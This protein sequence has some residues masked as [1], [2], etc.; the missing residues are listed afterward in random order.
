MK[1][2]ISLSFLLV[3]FLAI[4]QDKI[5]YI[6]YDE[7]VAEVSKLAIDK[8]YDKVLESLNKISKNDSTYCSVLT[9]K[10][11]Y[12]IQQEKYNEA[13]AITN[14]GL[15]LDCDSGSKLFFTM[16]KGVSLESL[17]RYNE[18][19]EVYDKGLELFPASDKLWYNKASCY[20]N[21]GDIPKTIEAYQKAI[22]LNPL[23]RNA[24]LFL[25]N[26]CYEQ[27]LTTQ[28]LM[29]YNM[30]LMVEPDS[31]RAFALLKYVNQAISDKN[32]NEPDDDLVV[33]ED[34][35]AFEDI[36]LILD[37]RIALNNKYKVDHPIDIAL[38]K[39]NH[40]MLEQ[41]EDFEGN[42]DFWDKRYVPI[43]KWIKQNEQFD[44]FIYTIVYSIKNEKF[45]KIVG[46]KTDDITSFIAGVISQS[47]DVFSPQSKMVDGTEKDINYYYADGRIQG[48]GEITN[49]TITGNWIYYNENGKITGKG[50]YDNN[51]ER[52]GKWSWYHDNGKLKETAHFKN[53]VINGKN[54][55]WYDNGKPNISTTITDGK[56]EGEYLYYLPSGALKQK[57]YYKVD[58]LDGKYLAYFNVGEAITEFDVDYKEGKIE[59]NVVEFYAN[60]DVYSNI[61]F[62]NGERNGLET[63]YYWNKQKSLEANY[64][65][66]ALNGSYVKYHSNGQ[67][68]EQGQSVD[69]FFDG[70][71]KTYYQ[72]GTL[73]S[74]IEY[75]EGKLTGIYKINDTDGKPY[76]EFEYRRGEII[77]YKYF[78]KEGNVLTE[79]R[80]KGGEFYFKGFHA[81]GNIMSEGQYDIKG[82][83]MGE[84]KFFDKNGVLT[85]DGEYK[86]NLT[87]GTHNTYY[88][89]GEISSVSEYDE[90]NL[91]GYYKA[92]HV[93]GNLE[94][95]GWYKDGNQHGEW[96]FYHINGVLKDVSFY[97]KGQ[98]HGKEEIYGTNGDLMK[99]I[100]YNYGTITKEVLYNPN[101][102]IHQITDKANAKQNYTLV[103]KHFN[104][105]KE[106][107]LDF[108]N[109]LKHGSYKNYDFDGN[110]YI[111]GSYVN[112][113]QNGEWIWR[114]PNG[115]IKYKQTYLNG[116]EDGKAIRYYENGQIEDDS[117]Y[118]YG[119]QHGEWVS[120][121]ED[122]TID[123]KTTYIKGNQHGR[124]EFYS[125]TGKFQLVRFYN[126]G[127]LI[128]YSYLDTSGK[129]K[130]MI[131]ITKETAKIEAFYQNG[132][133]SRTM[134][135]KN[136]QITG[137]YKAYYFDGT[138]ENELK[139]KNGEYHGD[140]VD[141]YKDGTIKNK[142]NYYFGALEGLAVHNYPNGKP[143]DV[144]NYKTDEMH[145]SR[146]YYNESG[147]LTKTETYFNGSVSK[148]E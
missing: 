49:K 99:E 128:G 80:K 53:G 91:T 97:H 50:S 74:E 145:G 8:D 31:E 132:K 106:V 112:D 111:T 37:N 115:D 12:L 25:G 79:N 41:L 82:G 59:N 38:V 3:S 1:K 76:N 11:Y 29:C 77:S 116:S 52:H 43:Y 134:E 138:L 13:I 98:A 10:S 88:T 5:P 142:Y 30:A 93:N 56:F 19:I 83:K 57:K 61:E 36:D 32:E 122:G 104:G 6:D 70:N 7:I 143:K 133:P 121:F 141:Y 27:N 20:K 17:E 21:L 67:I 33:S 54:E 35:E 92:F 78:D 71:W 148:T 65:D 4:S 69:G 51:S 105:N 144:A 34:D 119:L 139:Y 39:Q 60:G 120:Y 16:N 136:G 85:D 86:D 127:T 94:T 46:K 68:S 23:H 114:Y 73:E 101:K 26:I 118:E 102:E 89:T 87:I 66:N 146:K 58:E 40:A 75:D 137:T 95:Q 2:I 131:P 55:L 113:A 125:Q 64:A 62:K 109:G 84:W 129:E 100:H 126:H 103:I 72:D 45:K 28:A 110:L 15:D 63:Q 14:E 124:K 117:N 147:Q 44:N 18:A 22:T 123:T 96:R 108:V 9:S 47:Y 81:N 42:G 48:E 90:G 140:Y 135:Y 24:H 107:E 130:E